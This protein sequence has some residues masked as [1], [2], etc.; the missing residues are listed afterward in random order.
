MHKEYEINIPLVVP[1][2]SDFSFAMKLLKQW[3]LNRIIALFA[4]WILTLAYC[5]TYI[6]LIP[7]VGGIS[8]EF[9]FETYRLQC[10]S[11]DK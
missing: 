10:I 7:F 9:F 4:I 6:D 8:T 1:A 2:E 11:H 3:I 5:C